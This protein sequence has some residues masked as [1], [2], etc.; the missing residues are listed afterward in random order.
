MPIR[1]ATAVDDAKYRPI[2]AERLKER[3]LASEHGPAR[4]ASADEFGIQHVNGLEEVGFKHRDSRNYVYLRKRF[5]KEVG[6]DVFI[7]DVPFTTLAFHLGFFDKL[8]V[9]KPLYLSHR[10]LP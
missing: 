7:L 10:T 1:E 5:D 6:H 3:K 4:F 8:G 2:L 9:E